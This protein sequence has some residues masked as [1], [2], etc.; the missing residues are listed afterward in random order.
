[1]GLCRFNGIVLFGKGLLLLFGSRIT[2]GKT[3]ER[4]AAEGTVA[5]TTDGALRL[6]VLCQ[7]KNRKVRSFPLYSF[8][9]HTGPPSVPPNWLRRN[10]GTL[11]AKKLRAFSFSLRMNSYS[12]P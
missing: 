4:M 1:M 8:G 6:L 7:E 2:L 3:P 11:E 5:V 10:G 9:I 12:D